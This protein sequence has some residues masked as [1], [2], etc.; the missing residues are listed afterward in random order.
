MTD[1]GASGGAGGTA[2]C[3]GGRGPATATRL[4]VVSARTVGGASGGHALRLAR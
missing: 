3:C 1:G 4:G 2:S